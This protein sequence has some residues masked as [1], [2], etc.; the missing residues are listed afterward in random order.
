MRKTKIICTLGPATDDKETVRQLI[1]SGMN[2]ARFN[3]SHGTYDE[4]RKRLDILEELREELQL[5]IAALLD[6]KG[7]EIRIGTFKEGRVTLKPGDQ[8]TLTSRQVEGDA[9]IVSITFA[10]LV[11]DVEVGSRILLDDG[12][13]EL[14]V[15]EITATDIICKVINGGTISDR[16]GVN[17]PGVSIS[18]DY[19]SPKDREDILF[20]IDNG[21]D[22]IAASFTRS[23]ADILEIR[24]ILDE[25]HCS[26]IRIIAKIENGEGVAN[27][28][29]ILR[30]SDGIMIARGDMGVEIPLEEVP[31]IQKEL[32]KKGYS[33]GRQVITATQML[34]SMMKN[35]RPTRAEAT[36]VANA[37]YDGTSAIMLSG[38]TAAGLYPVEAVRTMARI[39]E[40]AE[41]DIDYKKRFYTRD[42]DPISDVTNA[43]SHATCTTAYDLG[44]SAIIT[45]TKTGT[46]ARMISKFRPSVPIIGG[47]MEPHVYRQLALSWGVLPLL[48]EEKKNTDVLFDHSV[49]Q[50]KKVGYVKDGDLVV[51]TAG[52]PL[53]ISGT[54]NMLKV[55]VVGDILVTGVG[56]GSA[57]V[58][59]NLCVVENEEEALKK[60]R[61]GDILV[62]P[63]TSNN[64]LSLMKK[65]AGI[66]TEIDGS[67][68]HA[69]IVGLALDIPVIVGAKNAVSILT[70]GTSVTVDARRGIVCN[71]ASAQVL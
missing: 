35:P 62:I 67:N 34:D 50:A 54:T 24:R 12:L 71:S 14:K 2:V 61:D 48:I 16:K 29:E 15:R 32:I 47:T 51:I 13:I 70:N 1:L 63:S 27:I 43:I 23:A 46:T 21:F 20:G 60:F 6:T 42:L 69:A 33:A 49:E 66:V 18:M 28:D 11:S 19:I 55:H 3:F 31:I 4:H 52:V 10:G 25:R 41:R 5:P 53:G 39:A 65:A 7:P 45:V 9:S 40:R 22:F 44:A 17:V 26:S 58:C 56:I 68:S 59:A 37:I 57:S 8:F 36:D 30:V 64:I 38:E